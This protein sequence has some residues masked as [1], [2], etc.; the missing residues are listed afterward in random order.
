MIPRLDDPI[1]LFQ[2][3]YAEAGTCGLAHPDAMSLATVDPDGMPSVRMVLLKGCDAGGFVFY[4]NTLSTKG[5]HLAGNPRAALCFYWEPLGR[6]VRVRGT[7]ER[8]SDAE[9][10]EYFASRPRGSRLG[11]WASRQSEPLAD[12]E[13]LLARLREYEARHPG[14]EI[15]RPPHWSGYRL[16]PESIEF[17]LEGE[18]RLH[19]RLLYRRTPEGGWTNELLHP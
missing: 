16:V 2:Q 5:R 15:P 18:F 7:T 17:W 10:D 4:T 8:V 9:A 11:A 6:Q 14:E 13:T 19:H 12:R 3:W 1:A